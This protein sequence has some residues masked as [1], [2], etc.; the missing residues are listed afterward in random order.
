MESFFILFFVIIDC[1]VYITCNISVIVND[2]LNKGVEQSLLWSSVSALMGQ[3]GVNWDH[4]SISP[5]SRLPLA[6][7]SPLDRGQS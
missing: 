6:P 2:K 1:I 3:T 7:P 5:K 4:T